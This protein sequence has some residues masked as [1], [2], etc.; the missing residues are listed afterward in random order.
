MRAG[1]V[2]GAGGGGGALRGAFPAFF[3]RS[4]VSAQD[5][6]ARF[7]RCPHGGLAQLARASALQAEG[8][9]FESV[10]LHEKVIDMMEAT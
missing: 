2:S 3:S 5:I 4:A 9:R 1:A 6:G 7:V 10:I 8:Q